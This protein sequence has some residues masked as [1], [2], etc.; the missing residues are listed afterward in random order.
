VIIYDEGPAGPP[1]HPH[2]TLG[3]PSDPEIPVIGTTY[4]LGKALLQAGSTA[5]I[6]VDTDNTESS[7][8]N[9]LA[10]TPG[11]NRDSV[12]VVGAHR[13]SVPEGPGINDN[14]PGVSGILEIAEQ[15]ARAGHHARQHR[16]LRLV[17][18]R[19]VRPGRL[20]GL[21]EHAARG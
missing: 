1:G 4:A 8:Y 14:G 6:V 15:M 19:G 7:S 5:R 12:I 21:R 16:A 9:V 17:G 11:G 13:D 2:G 18:R 10:D 20:D 3:A